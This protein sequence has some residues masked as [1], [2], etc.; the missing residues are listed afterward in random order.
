MR[1]RASNNPAVSQQGRHRATGIP[2]AAAVAV[3]ALAI[4]TLATSAQ[5]QAIEHFHAG[6]Q[7]KVIIGGGTGGGYDFYG[8]LLGQYIARHL[9]GKPTMVPTGMP[10]AGGI[11]AANY[12]YNVAPRDGSEIGIVGR[13]VS[14]Q[15]LIAPNDKGPKYIATKFNWLGTPTQEVGVLVM[16]LPSKIRTLQDLRE[17][18][19]IVSGTSAA[20]PPSFYPLIMNKL[21][22]TKFKVVSGYEGSQPALL[23][24]ERGEVEGHLA[25]SVALPVRERI[26]PWIKAGTAAILAQIGIEKDPKNGDAPLILDLARSTIERRVM[27]LI[28]AQQVTA[29]PF[30]APPELPP[31]RVKALRAAFDAAVADREFL[32]EAEKLKLEIRPMGGEQIQDFLVQLYQSPKEILDRVSALSE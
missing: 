19:L 23:A 17:Q 20:A 10:G 8:R 21:F 31:D 3:R 24:M 13:A 7:L 12:L 1:H 9:P 32:A 26:T 14:T 16:R 22:G 11:V 5:A 28:L 15:P 30:L 18:E 2:R 6:K 4:G 27:E 29:W 25:S